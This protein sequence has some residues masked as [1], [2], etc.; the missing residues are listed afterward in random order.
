[1]RLGSQGGPESFYLLAQEVA[2]IT[3]ITGQV[4]CLGPLLLRGKLCSSLSRK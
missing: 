3:G 1:M 2:D 4:F